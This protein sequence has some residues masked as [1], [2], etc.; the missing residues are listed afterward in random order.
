MSAQFGD[1]RTLEVHLF[2]ETL[3][4]VPPHCINDCMNPIFSFSWADNSE[5]NIVVRCTTFI[6][7]MV[8][9]YAVF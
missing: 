7:V 1:K 2:S 9:T 8:P 4:W 3:D 5:A 6:R